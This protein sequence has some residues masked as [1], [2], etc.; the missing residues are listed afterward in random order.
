M[1]GRKL[2]SLKSSHDLWFK[3][4][5]DRK[6]WRSTKSCS[7]RAQSRACKLQAS[8]SS[9][10]ILGSKDRSSCSQI[11]HDFFPQYFLW[12]QKDHGPSTHTIRRLFWSGLRRH[13][14]C[15]IASKQG[16]DF[17]QG[18]YSLTTRLIYLFCTEMNIKISQSSDIQFKKI[19]IA[20][21]NHL[22][23]TVKQNLS[24]CASFR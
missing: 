6:S 16:Q 17:S 1:H 8:T 14:S 24:A 12:W 3:K 23:T 13:L 21:R 11:I 18:K 15:L 2:S 19:H 4:H 9:A 7:T 10:S 22:K 20:S 5:S